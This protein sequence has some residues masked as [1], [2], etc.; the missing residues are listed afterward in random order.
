MS[1]ASVDLSEAVY[2]RLIRLAT[3]QGQAPEAILEQALADYER[4]LLSGE[5]WDALNRRRAELIARK[6]RAELTDEERAEFERLQRI[7]HEALERQ[8]PRPRL[9]PGELAEVK[10]A[11]GLSPKAQGQ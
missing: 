8:F 3:Q 1:T 11:L 2:Q 10:N 7:S 5:A 9:T 6:A 4:R